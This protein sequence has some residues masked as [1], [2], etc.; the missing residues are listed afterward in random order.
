M[1]I[2]LTSTVIHAQVGIN[3]TAPENGSILDVTST[4]KGILI[5]RVSIADL[6]TIAPVT[7][8][9]TESLLV[10]NTN[11]STGKGF[12]YWT[13]SVWQPIDSDWKLRGN[14]GTD[15]TTHFI[16][17]TDDEDFVFKT[18]NAEAM[19]VTSTEGIL[20]IGKTVRGSSSDLLQVLS[21]IEIGGGTTNYDFNSENIEM[22]S[23]SR[24][25]NINALNDPSASN[26]TFFIGISEDEE[27]AAITLAPDGKVK[28][29]MSSDDLP[30]STLHV[31]EDQD[32]AATTIR[33]DNSSTVNNIP[34]TSLELWDGETYFKSFFRH[35]NVSNTLQL[36]HAEHDGRVEIHAGDGSASGSSS[37]AMVID[38][39]GEVSIGEDDTTPDDLLHITKDQDATTTL[40][41][42]NSN[43]GTDTPHTELALFDGTTVGGGQ[44]A[45]FRHNNF[46]YNL[47]IGHARGTGVVNFYSGN[48]GA[49]ASDSGI[50]MTLENDSSVT[51]QSVLNLKPGSAPASPKKGDIY[52]DSSDDRVKVWNGSSWRSMNN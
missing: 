11:T 14:A 10:Y 17:T 34:H 27:D 19:R 4:D 22:S 32:N 36:G 31:V 50:S 28:V 40:R 1:F 47:D 41:I 2:F 42:D 33:I 9:G 44:M 13:G 20:L 49:A 37:T 35:N 26:S 3:T 7:G 25:W 51:I 12:H 48:G 23:Q 5:P 30:L 52:Y 45:F 21:D 38:S 18:N 24:Q 43:D 29:G 6:S 15:D 46:N 39:D 16:G 8:G